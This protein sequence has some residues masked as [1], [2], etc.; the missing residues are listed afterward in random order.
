[1]P[2]THEKDFFTLLEKEKELEKT[3]KI[4]A[5]KAITIISKQF[6]EEEKNATFIKKVGWII[7]DFFAVFRL[8]KIKRKHDKK[9]KNLTKEDKEDK[10]IDKKTFKKNGVL[11]NI[12]LKRYFEK[13]K[14]LDDCGSID[15]SDI[16]YI[17]GITLELNSKVSKWHY[18]KKFEKEEIALEY[19]NILVKEYKNKNI[20]TIFSQL[21]IDMDNA[22]NNFNKQ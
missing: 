7:Y 18:T 12:Y 17:V 22:I 10:I 13:C 19:F 1:M 16:K 21:L 3:Q 2:N 11:L 20:K 9:I 14:L 8:K 15:I 4:H 5:E 6:E